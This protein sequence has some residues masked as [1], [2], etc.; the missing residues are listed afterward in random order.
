MQSA[1]IY[2]LIFP[3]AACSVDSV[4]YSAPMWVRSAAAVICLLGGITIS[5]MFTLSL[6]D[7]SWAISTGLGT[8]LAAG[9]YELGRPARLSVE[10]AVQL[11]GQWQDF[12]K[13]GEGS[14]WRGVMLK[15]NNEK[16]K[17]YGR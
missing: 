15:K 11:E 17:L 12:G 5:L 8:C 2:E 16:S 1:A 10:E 9:V 4:D 3:A 7:S 14:V 6:G 13:R